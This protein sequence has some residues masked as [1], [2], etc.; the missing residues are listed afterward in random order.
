M[1]WGLLL[2]ACRG[3]AVPVV[4]VAPALDHAVV[5]SERGGTRVGEP[6]PT[7]VALHGLGDRPEDFVRALDGLTGPVRVVAVQA[8]APWGDD[9]HAWWTRR[10]RDG[11]WSVLAADVSS[12]AD[13]LV[14]LLQSLG[15]DESV[16]GKPVVTGFSQGG[17]LSYAL[18]S[19]HPQDIAGAVPVS[20]M[21]LDGVAT[22]SWATTRALHGDADA[23]VP[24]QR[25]KGAVDALT[26]SGEDVS[27]QSFPGVAHRIPAQVRSAWYAELQALLPACEGE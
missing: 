22:S 21:I 3:P 15:Q 5:V 9:G 19:R 13:A 27:V 18:A 12:A 2:F 4:G 14:P 16:C 8:P 24:Y 26:A 23:V 10:V 6:L 17:M 20:G 1:V 7:V 11:D 25:T